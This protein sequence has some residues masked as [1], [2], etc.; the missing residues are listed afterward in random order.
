MRQIE[1]REPGGPEVLALA[2]GPVPQPRPHEVLIRVEAAGVNRP[3]LMQRAGKYPP[4]PD[5]SPLIGLEVAGE[6]VAVGAEVVNWHVGDRATA[7]TNGGGYAE[8][9]VAPAAQC[10][11]WPAG[12]DAVRAAALPETYF[13]VWANLFQHGRL[14]RG[15][16]VLVHGGTSGIG[17]TAIQLARE[18]GARVYATAGSDDKCAACLALGADG[19]INYRSTDFAERLMELTGGAGVNVVL[20]I[21]GA[22]YFERNLRCLAMDGRLVEVSTQLG[23][24][25]ERFDLL[26]VMQRR[27]VITGSTM[28]PRTTAEKGAIAQALRERV[29]PVLNAG[30]CGPL[31]YA[32][33]PL[34][35]AAAAHALL[36]SSVHVGKVMLKVAG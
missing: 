29:W 22:P 28:R 13:T 11:P 27:L 10:L 24:K 1:A 4:P 35:E 16:A 34:A 6:V 3:D 32:T 12:F 14:A 30:R 26:K 2:T 7:L 9:C 15:E 33:F 21:V 31:V 36:E 23:S 18:F 17:V 8:Y 25:V 20:D 19:A 5:A